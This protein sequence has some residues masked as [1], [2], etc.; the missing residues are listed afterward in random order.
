MSLDKHDDEVWRRAFDMRQ[1]LTPYEEAKIFRKLGADEAMVLH[2]CIAEPTEDLHHRTLQTRKD[3]E[4]EQA[5][6]KKTINDDLF[7]PEELDERAQW[8][9]SAADKTPNEILIR[10]KWIENQLLGLCVETAKSAL[11]M[12]VT[13]E[14]D[15]IVGALEKRLDRRNEQVKANSPDEPPQGRGV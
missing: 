5:L 1:E 13:Y 15:Q 9:A 11:D 2:L 4:A 10:A 14:R 3:F 7:T 8:I 6:R 12:G